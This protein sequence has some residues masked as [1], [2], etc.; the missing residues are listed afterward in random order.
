MIDSSDQPFFISKYFDTKSPRGENISRE[1]KKKRNFQEFIKLDEQ[2]PNNP[3]E[4]CL[5]RPGK[6]L[7]LNLL[8]KSMKYDGITSFR[9]G[10]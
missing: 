7:P 3:P 2:P 6:I 10:F 8:L 5:F 4:L 9:K 1:V